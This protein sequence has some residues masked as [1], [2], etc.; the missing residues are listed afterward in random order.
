ML[1]KQYL[2]PALAALFILSCSSGSKAEPEI[3]FVDPGEKTDPT[4]AEQPSVVTGDATNIT[5]TAAKIVN[6]Y[7]GAPSSG[8]YDRGV[9]YGTSADALTQ[10]V[11]LNSN[12]GTSGT[13]NVQLVSLEP[14]TTYY[15]QAYITVWSTDANKYVDVLGTVKSF[16]TEDG[17]GS[18][19]GG[20]GGGGSIA[21]LQYLGCYE[22]PAIDLKNTSACSGSG[23]ETWGTTSWFNYLT[24][25]DNQM[26]V[27]HTY[28]YNGKQYRNWTALIDKDRKS[29]LWTAFVMQKDAYPD[30]NI[31]RVGNWTYGD[32][33]KSNTDPGIPAAWQKSVASSTHSRGHHVASDYRQ[34]CSDANWQTFYWTNQSLQFQNGFNSG[35][36]SSLEQ[37]VVTNA[38]SGR[39]TTYVVVGILFEDPNN[40]ITTNQ[41]TTELAPS[42]Y[43]KCLMKCSFDSSGAMTAAKGCAYLFENKTYPNKEAYNNHLTTI[44]AIEQRSGWDF[45]TNVPASLQ[46]TAEAQ[47]ASI[48]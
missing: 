44:D 1:M 8:A 16:T 21:G 25:N 14:K 48:W 31:G 7:S 24:G 42:H 12:K 4:P 3:P 20:E 5:S 32:D 9:Y 22:M 47:S 43:Y 17:S 36:W 2:L 27:T 18:G 23:P 40:I 28:A 15:Y 35:V 30:N 26:V 6:K 13:F 45:F 41:G 46:A 29:P 34:A 10:Q 19:G 11:A 33:G 37:A 38:P 39:D